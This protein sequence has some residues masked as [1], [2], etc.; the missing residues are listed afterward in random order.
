NEK[1]AVRFNGTL[2]DIT[3]QARA[4]HEIEKIVEERTYLLNKSNADLTQFAYIASHDLQEPAR[5]ISTFTDMLVR[6]LGETLD[7][8][9]KEYLKKIDG[10][11]DRMLNL[12]RGVLT[13][14]KI[15]DSRNNFDAVN[16]DTVLRDA[17]ND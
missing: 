1:V 2:Q 11:S 4:R 12:I 13:I 8:Q 14:S 3:S 7:E 5:K 17:K 16:L 9:S 15:S 6:R 10:S